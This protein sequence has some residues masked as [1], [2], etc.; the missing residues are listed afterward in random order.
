VL[1]GSSVNAADGALNTLGGGDASTNGKLF[2]ATNSQ[3]SAINHVSGGLPE[4]SS[5]P[6]GQNPFTASTTPNIPDLAGGV[7]APYG[8]LAN[9]QANSSVF[10]GIAANAPTHTLA[11]VLLGSSG[12]P[13]YSD[14]FP[15][16]QWVLVVNLSGSALNGLKIGLS[17]NS[18]TF[19]AA[20]AQQNLSITGSGTT[21][22][23]H[24][25]TSTGIPLPANDVYAFLAPTSLI[26][27]GTLYATADGALPLTMTSDYGL[28]TPGFLPVGYLQSAS[29]TP[30][31][32][33]AALTLAALSGLLLLPRGRAGAA[34][35]SGRA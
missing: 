21:G 12:L 19:D 3:I 31:P 9:L 7:A 18:A 6:V 27:S 14:V 26:D 5:G 11:A 1:A 33:A 8:I 24:I 15:G 20:L 10:S 34:P 30:E 29:A 4:Y 28:V 17:S 25:L 35:T 2:I 23:I 22:N 16:Y 13:G 32:A